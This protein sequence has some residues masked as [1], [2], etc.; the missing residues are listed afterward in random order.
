M[1]AGIE[2]QENSLVAQVS[3]QSWAAASSDWTDNPSMEAT[4]V[5]T[6][7]RIAQHAQVDE[8][9]GP[10]ESLDQVMPDRHRDRRLA[11]AAGTDDRDQACSV[12]PSRKPENI[13]VAP[14]HPDRAGRAGCCSGRRA[15]D[16]GSWAGS[17]VSTTGATK[18]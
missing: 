7:L 6:R 9:H 13:V 4:A 1:L 5:A 12:Q 14:D 16:A 8:E 2:D 11:D 17:P 18:Q 15:A 3:D 10:R